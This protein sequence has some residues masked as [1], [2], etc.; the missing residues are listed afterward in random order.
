MSDQANDCGDLIVFVPVGMRPLTG[1]RR[2]VRASGRTI[3][4]LIDDL[5]SRY[6]GFR[7]S[8][9][10]Q[11]QLKRGL[12][13]AVNSEEQPLGLLAKVPSG[14]E[15]HFLPAMAGGSLNKACYSIRL[16]RPVRLTVSA[17]DASV[18]C[19]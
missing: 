11:R 16:N 8:L 13:V 19:P 18:I 14:A 15:V 1:G 5:E 4:E 12:T 2:I 3:A 9:I 6:P 17:G 10:E 7:P